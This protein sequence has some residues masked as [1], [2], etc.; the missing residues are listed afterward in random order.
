MIENILVVED[1]QPLNELICSNLES[2]GYETKGVYTGESAVKEFA[3]GNYGLVLMDYELGSG[4]HGGHATR[5][6]RLVEDKIDKTSRSKIVCT[7]A[8][9]MKESCKLWGMDVYVGKIV[10]KEDLE[11]VID[12][13]LPY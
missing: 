6:I 13:Y 2:L 11:K 5:M 1:S 9:D 3:K 8:N 10:K 7:S 12:K 4:I